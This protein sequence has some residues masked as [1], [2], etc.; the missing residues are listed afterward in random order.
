MTEKN[1]EEMLKKTLSEEEDVPADTKEELLTKLG[2]VPSTGGIKFMRIARN[3]A[4]VAACFVLSICVFANVSKTAYD[5][6]SEIPVVG[7]FAKALTFRTYEDN[8]GGFEA[9]MEVPKVDGL[10][11]AT[12]AVNDEI[13]TYTK[14]LIAMYEKEKTESNGEGLLHM[15]S[16]YSTVG[17][18]ED[19]FSLKIWANTAAASSA[20][21]NKF[22]TVDKKKESIV[23]FSDLFPTDNDKA[24]LRRLIIE[25]MNALEEIDS[26]RYSYYKENVIIDDNTKFYITSDNEIVISFD[27]YE[28]SYG[29]A[30]VIEFRVGMVENGKAVLGKK[31]VDAL[32]HIYGTVVDATMGTIIVSEHGSDE[33]Y[34]FDKQDVDIVSHGDG[35]VLGCEVDIYYIGSLDNAE[36]VRIEIY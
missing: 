11:G 25:R 30:G 20:E 13:D 14:E 26:S 7:S 17:D 12:S 34:M 31:P 10:G 6:L 8:S 27:E 9:Y 19:Y 4:A 18:N 36:V 33:T 23:R 21:F 15:T 1:I 32:E 22:I 16:G 2:C 35:I 3:A 24:E 5:V 29:A 28:V